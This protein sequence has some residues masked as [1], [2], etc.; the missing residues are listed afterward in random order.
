M[1]I[2]RSEEIPSPL[3]NT[4]SDFFPDVFVS[5]SSFLS[6]P[7]TSPLHLYNFTF[8]LHYT[9]SPSHLCFCFYITSCPY[10][11]LYTRVWQR[12]C[13]WW[14]K[15]KFPFLLVGLVFFILQQPAEEIFKNA[16]D[17]SV[18]SL[19]ENLEMMSFVSRNYQKVY[20]KSLWNYR[21]SCNS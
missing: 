20:G 2:C 13:S 19:P 7:M 14:Q 9:S 12:G 11:H 4:T 15:S 10:S 16:I 17:N 5:G 18:I 6:W 8:F 1:R 21:V 3:L